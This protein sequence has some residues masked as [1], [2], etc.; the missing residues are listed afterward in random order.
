MVND[1]RP[2]TRL[3][4]RDEYVYD[5]LEAGVRHTFDTSKPRRI[6]DAL[7]AAGVALPADFVAPAAVAEDELRLVH[8]ADYLAEIRRPQVLARLL[9]LDPAHPWDERL[10]HPF[11]FA[12]GGTVAAARWAATQRGIGVNLGGGFHH[13]QVDKAEGFCAIADVAIAIRLLQRS[14]QVRRVLI[15]DLDYHHGNGNAEIFS[16]D[17]EVFT[18]SL[19]AGNWCWIAKRYNRD[20]ELPERTSDAAYLEALQAHLPEIVREFQPDFAVYIAGS[21]P[22][23]EDELGDF[24]VSEAGMLVRDQLVTNQLW[25]RG[26]AMVVVTAGGYGESSWRIHFNYFRWLL[27]GAV[28]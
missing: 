26:I 6:R 7:V 14:H 28:Q 12:A 22:F 24:A 15:V 4:Y 17:E 9:F 5:V 16:R 2:Y 23:I 8:T 3:F 27:S 13:A 20:V 19:H 10:L 21:D 11:L 1:T 18:F 25:G